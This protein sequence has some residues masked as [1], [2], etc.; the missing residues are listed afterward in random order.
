MKSK[1]NLDDYYGEYTRNIKPDWLYGQLEILKKKILATKG[2]GG[3][4]I[5]AGNGASAAIASHVALDF[6]KTS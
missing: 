3:K 2:F 6:T 1:L 4:V 5:F